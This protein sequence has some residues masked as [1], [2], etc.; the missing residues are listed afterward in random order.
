MPLLPSLDVDVQILGHVTQVSA[1]QQNLEQQH[2]LLQT[3]IGQNQAGLLGVRMQQ[4]E[5]TRHI[6]AASARRRSQGGQMCARRSSR[7]TDV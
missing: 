4:R 3:Q 2:P 1:L 7:A 5:H 6:C